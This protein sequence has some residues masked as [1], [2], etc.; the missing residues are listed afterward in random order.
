MADTYWTVTLKV[1]AFDTKEQAEEYAEA[2]AGAL[3]A[4]PETEAYA[5][6]PIVEEHTDE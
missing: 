1:F 5:V 4:M 2:M 3:V 6:G